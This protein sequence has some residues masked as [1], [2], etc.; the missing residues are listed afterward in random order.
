MTSHQS[1][2]NPCFF[3]SLPNEL[4]DDIFVHCLPEEPSIVSSID[5]PLLF[6]AVCKRWKEIAL[7][8]TLLWKKVYV[9]I[10][11]EFKDPSAD[12]EK[13]IRRI[14]SLLK[15]W[16][17]V[18]A[19]A[20]PERTFQVD[21][22]VR[23]DMYNLA[24][25]YPDAIFCTLRQPAFL[26]RIRSIESY[27]VLVFCKEDRRPHIPTPSSAAWDALVQDLSSLQTVSHI[28][29]FDTPH[30]G[31]WIPPREEY[32]RA[33]IVTGASS[34]TPGPALLVDSFMADSFVHTWHEDPMTM[35]QRFVPVPWN[36]LTTL[37]LRNTIIRDEAWYHRLLKSITQLPALE[38]LT[39]HLSGF[40][41]NGPHWEPFVMPRLT[42]LEVVGN[43]AYIDIDY[44]LA[45]FLRA[46]RPPALQ[47]L[48]VSRQEDSCVQ[49]GAIMT[50]WLR[51]L[52]DSAPSLTSL[53]ISD[54]YVE[55]GDIWRGLVERPLT[56][57]SLR[58]YPAYAP[59][60]RQLANPLVCPTLEAIELE[61]V[62]PTKEELELAWDIEAKRRV[63]K[64]GVLTE[65]VLT[66]CGNDETS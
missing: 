15:R 60:L 50:I 56:R 55:P 4:V 57:F 18:S 21:V 53:E 32:Q 16:F 46:L 48:V 31:Q 42:H 25:P 45:G 65:F 44:R 13:S 52:L 59:V 10:A 22:V 20:G 40:N 51:D 12:S 6:L 35:L 29:R 62:H 43:P 58:V 3:E 1:S 24:S 37:S 49:H 41:T 2:S 38:S 7:A 64:G 19:T 30:L 63:A 28:G 17:Q 61:V 27:G 39:L 33:R 36:S 47:R 34:P 9:N 26:H 23:H 5:A 14:L 66:S 11:Q 54:P 8:S